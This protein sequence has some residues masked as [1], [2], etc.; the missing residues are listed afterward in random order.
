MSPSRENPVSGNNDEQAIYRI[1]VKG[2]LDEQ[3]SDWFDGLTIRP[4]SNEATILTGAIR[5]QAA[6]HGLLNKI[7]DLG[8]TLLSVER[9]NT[10]SINDCG[11]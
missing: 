4:Y 6:L 11:R 8:L 2:I 1:K 5:D 7:R 9:V 10:R 3:W